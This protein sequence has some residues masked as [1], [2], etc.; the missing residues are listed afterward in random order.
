MTIALLQYIFGAMAFPKYWYICIL[1]YIEHT[2]LDNGWI[3]SFKFSSEIEKKK[4]VASSEIEK[5]KQLYMHLS[6]FK[7]FNYGFF[8]YSMELTIF[9]L[10]VGQRNL[11]IL[12]FPQTLNKLNFFC[13]FACCNQEINWLRKNAENAEN[14]SGKTNILFIFFELFATK[15]L[16]Q[17]FVEIVKFVEETFTCIKR[18]QIKIDKNLRKL[19]LTRSSK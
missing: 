5:N 16:I 7:F 8:I 11:F 10:V 17:F 13:G 3:Q 18:L 19:K 4:A 1:Y 6:K 14:N 9:N 15:S 2:D 12:I